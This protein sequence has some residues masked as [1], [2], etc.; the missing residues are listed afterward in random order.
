[1]LD[2]GFSDHGM[3]R[4]STWE[5]AESGHRNVVR[6]LQEG[7]EPSPDEPEDVIEGEIVPE[8]PAIEGGAR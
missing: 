4:Y 2:A 5:Q 3:W 8:R 1:M 6:C 7:R